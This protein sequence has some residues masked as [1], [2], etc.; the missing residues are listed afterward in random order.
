MTATD[1][2]F[3]GSIPQFYDRYLGPFLFRPFAEVLAARVAGLEGDLL[4][5]AAGTGVVTRALDKALAPSARIVATDLNQAMLDHAAAQLSS[6]RV[7]WRQADGQALP[8]G[9]GGFD[10]VVCQFGVMFFPDRGAGYAEARRVLRP[11]GRY[12]FNVWDSLQANPDSQAVHEAVAALFPDDPPGFLAR[13]PFGYSDKDR[14]R[15]DVAAAGFSRIEIETV[16]KTGRAGSARDV[17]TGL[18][19]GSPLRAEIEAR[20]PAALPRAVDAAAKALEARYGTGAFESP[21]QA[22]VVTAER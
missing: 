3:T 11:G 19:E 20:D 2:A 6:P 5:I 21:L 15:A 8:F 14:I 7:E 4:E 10:A 1:K 18:C 22:L 12:L 17:A 13:T 16:A 9:D